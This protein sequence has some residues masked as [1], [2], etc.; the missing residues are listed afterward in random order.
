[1]KSVQRSGYGTLQTNWETWS[2]NLDV[3][4]ALAYAKHFPNIERHW[5]HW[6]LEET[7]MYWGRRLWDEEFG[8]ADVLWDVPLLPSHMLWC[9]SCYV[10]YILHESSAQNV[11]VNVF[12]Q[13]H[14][15]HVSSYNLKYYISIR[16]MGKKVNFS[17]EK[18]KCGMGKGRIEVHTMKGWVCSIYI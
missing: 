14:G 5:A 8:L 9:D 7:G 13:L 15:F 1:M 4:S 11:L 3:S 16:T 18:K 12:F 10:W 2:T 17:G 6:S